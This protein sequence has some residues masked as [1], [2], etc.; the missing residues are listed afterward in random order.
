M[1]GAFTYLY[2]GTERVEM[3]Q[4]SSEDISVRNEDN[5]KVTILQTNYYQFDQT[6]FSL[7]TEI[8]KSVVMFVILLEFIMHQKSW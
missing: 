4:Q 3:Q 2:I 5:W 8:M 6:L 7:S 1:Q